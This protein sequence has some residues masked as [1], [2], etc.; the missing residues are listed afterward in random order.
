[1]EWTSSH[2]RTSWGWGHSSH[3]GMN[4]RHILP[5]PKSLVLSVSSLP[6]RFSLLPTYLPPSYLPAPSYL[7]PTYLPLH[8]A[9]TPSLELRR[10][11]SRS[12]DNVL[13]ARAKTMCLKRE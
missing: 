2:Q 5:Y 3:L 6:Q 7:P 8:F 11:W 1:L 12:Q 13:N 9:L 4:Q 10:A